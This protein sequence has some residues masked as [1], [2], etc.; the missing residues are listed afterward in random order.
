MQRELVNS[1]FGRFIFAN[2]FI[3]CVC[4]C[5]CGCECVCERERERDML[6]TRP[7]SVFFWVFSNIFFFRFSD[8]GG[9]AKISDMRV[10]VFCWGDHTQKKESFEKTFCE[11]KIRNKKI[12]RWREKIQNKKRFEIE[13]DLILSFV[14]LIFHM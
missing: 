10:T 8:G 1:E 5:V 7:G 14:H 11:K 2:V 6:N 9:L 13:S 4:V 12:H 3:V